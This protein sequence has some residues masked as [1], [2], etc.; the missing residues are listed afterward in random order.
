MVKIIL[1]ILAFLVLVILLGLLTAK[2][3]HI[4]LDKEPE[5]MS[6]HSFVLYNILK[7]LLL[8]A[9]LVIRLFKQK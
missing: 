4:E 3:N 6:E 5:E 9:K 1:L 2:L 7:P 8:P